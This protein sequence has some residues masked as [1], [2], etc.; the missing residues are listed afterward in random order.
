M[1]PIVERISWEGHISGFISGI[2]LALLYGKKLKNKYQDK[3]FVKIYPEDE[4]FLNHF[5]KN[6]NFIENNKKNLEKEK[7]LNR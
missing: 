1:F 2:F 5:D 3:N 4:L 6:G 7:T